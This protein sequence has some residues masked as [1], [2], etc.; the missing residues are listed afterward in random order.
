MSELSIEQR[1][2]L[3]KF[4]KGENLFITGPGGTGK[5]KLINS[6]VNHMN[7]SGIN[8]QGRVVLRY[9]SVVNREPFIHGPV[10]N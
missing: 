3:D 7:Q 4:K 6:L 2:A 9:C 1:Y 8:Y 5:T 10:L